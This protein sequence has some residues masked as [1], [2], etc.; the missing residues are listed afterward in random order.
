MFKFL[1][2]LFIY[3]IK[4]ATTVNKE[5]LKFDWNEI[6]PQLVAKLGE[7]ALFSIPWGHHREIITK[8]KDKDEAIFYIAK[9][10]ENSWSRNILVLQI[11]SKLYFNIYM[12]N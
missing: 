12:R 6:L 10:I 3:V 7:N 9:T 8:I 11:E 2:S 5:L 4:A 1:I